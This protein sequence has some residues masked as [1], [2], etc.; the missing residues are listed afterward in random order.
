[1]LNPDRY[2]DPAPGVRD[3]RPRA[4]RARRAPAAGLPARPRR[5]AHP[6]REH[7]VPRSGGAARHPRSLRHADALLAGRRRSSALGVPSLDGT[8]V[9]TDSRAHLA[10]LRRA[11]ATCSAARRAAAGCGTSS[12]TCSAS[13]SRSTPAT[14]TP[15]TIASTRSCAPTRSGRARCSSASGSRCSAPPTPPPTP[16]AWHQQI[17]DSGLGR[18][19][20][21]DVPAR[22]RHQHPAPGLAGGDGPARRR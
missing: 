10:A 22:P 14:P 13:T 18:L 9:E 3:R 17:R 12:P 1:M 11:H 7:A 21:A 4:L 19:G 6:G 20:A 8:P 16:L 15:S 5:P 2:F